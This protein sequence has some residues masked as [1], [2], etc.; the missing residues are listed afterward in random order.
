MRH[1]VDDTKL[2]TKLLE[3]SIVKGTPFEFLLEDGTTLRLT[4]N[5]DRVLLQIDE[6]DAPIL[7]P[8]GVPMYHLTSKVEMKIIPKNKIIYIPKL[9]TVKSDPPPRMS[10]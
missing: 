7:N 9:S 6:H 1:M 3:F 2:R 10:I 8:E 5:L 4:L